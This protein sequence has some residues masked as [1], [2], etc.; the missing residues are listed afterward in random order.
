MQN[1]FLKARLINERST[2]IILENTSLET[3]NPIPNYT[4]AFLYKIK[5][6]QGI[7]KYRTLNFQI[8][9]P[10][11]YPFKSPKII[12]LDKIFHPNIDFDGN[13]CLGFIREKWTCSKGL[14]D[15]VFGIY[16]ILIDVCG[17]EPLN[18]EAGEMFVNDYDEFLKRA[19][20]YR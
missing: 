1:T 18:Q 10:E 4:A 7:Y 15:L 20:T 2:L 12:C 3:C 5:V 8:N 9:I 14:Q 17:D 11:A 6:K 13:V 16:S 19:Q